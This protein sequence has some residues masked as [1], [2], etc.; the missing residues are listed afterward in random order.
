MIEYKE[1]PTKVSGST[2]NKVSSK[3]R[4]IYLR[5]G[6]ENNLKDFILNF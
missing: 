5:L 2:L 1:Y 4:K 6:L 3:K